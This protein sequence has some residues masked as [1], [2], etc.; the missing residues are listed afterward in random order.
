MAS[1][2]AVIRSGQ[3]HLLAAAFGYGREQ[4]VPALFRH[5][6][7][8]RTAADLQAP[9]LAW[10]LDR[11]IGLDGDQHGPL[12][13]QMVLDHCRVPRARDQRA[14]KAL[15]TEQARRLPTS[16]SPTPSNTHRYLVVHEHHTY[17]GVQGIRWPV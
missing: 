3:A 7:E 9:T 15:A 5:L 11:H 16:C 8:Q 14:V 6:Q 4:L 13:E 10:H 12:T 1:T 17:G 2:Q